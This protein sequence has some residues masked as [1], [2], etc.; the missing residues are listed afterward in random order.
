MYGGAIYIAS[1][2]NVSSISNSI[3]DGNGYLPAPTPSSPPTAAPEQYGGA[4]YSNGGCLS[5][6]TDSAFLG[7]GGSPNMTAGGAL[8]LSAPYCSPTLSGLT[9]F[10]NS[11]GVAGG[12]VSLQAFT[13]PITVFSSS[14]VNNTVG[15]GAGRGGEGGTG[16][17]LLQRVTAAQGSE[18]GC[19]VAERAGAAVSLKFPAT[20]LRKSRPEASCPAAHVVLQAGAFSLYKQAGST[21]RGGAL[22][23]QVRGPGKKGLIRGSNQVAVTRERRVAR[24][25]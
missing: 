9:F 25:E 15:K 23:M 13:Q 12:A 4:V 19:N 21:A 20:L 3:F 16:A 22:Y 8:Y 17:R 18:R 5:S 2:G 14:F 11:A 7:N 24:G 10:N 6:V 1:G